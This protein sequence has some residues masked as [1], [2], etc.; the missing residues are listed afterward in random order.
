MLVPT[1]VTR[2]GK[3][4]PTGRKR[5]SDLHG[6]I[7]MRGVGTEAAS[8]NAAA[9]AAETARLEKKQKTE[10][11]KAAAEREMR[12]RDEAFARC[13]HGCV[14]GV[15]PC[16]WAKWKR[17]P[18]CG[19]KSGLCKVRACVAARK[20]LLLGYNPAVEGQEVTGG[21]I[22]ARVFSTVA[23]HVL[24]VGCTGYCVW[25]RVM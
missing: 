25:L 7:T 23:V 1:T 2:Q 19:P 5:L 13:E 17:C 8:R 15:V 18:I 9:K 4:Q 6:S 22:V 11:Q 3:Q 10:E 14:C 20:P 12:E 16:P 21:C 24:A